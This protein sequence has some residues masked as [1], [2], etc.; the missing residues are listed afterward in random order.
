MHGSTCLDPMGEENDQVGL[1]ISP[2]RGLGPGPAPAGYI[3]ELVG[4]QAGAQAEPPE[5]KAAPGGQGRGGVQH[6][7]GPVVPMGGPAEILLSLSCCIPSKHPLPFN[8]I[9]FTSS[10][11][12]GKFKKQ[13]CWKKCTVKTQLRFYNECFVMLTLSCIYPRVH[14]STNSRSK[15][16]ALLRNSKT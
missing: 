15:T 3:Q 11:I 16:T 7:E 2:I 12:F 9:V 13:E 10:T 4:T 5:P 6:L 8:Q 14:P 1:P